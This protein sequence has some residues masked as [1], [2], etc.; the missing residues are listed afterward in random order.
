MVIPGNKLTGMQPATIEITR[1][2]QSTGTRLH[3]HYIGIS[4][5]Q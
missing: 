4:H 3:D 2:D 5:F 1:R